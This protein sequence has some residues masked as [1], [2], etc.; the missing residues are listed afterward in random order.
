MYALVFVRLVGPQLT[1]ERIYKI[2]LILPVRALVTQYLKQ[3]SR[4]FSKLGMKLGVNKVAYVDCL[5]S[6]FFR[7]GLAPPPPG[8]ECGGCKS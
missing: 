6:F 4:R 8:G 2:A 5:E 7:K 1:T 3:H